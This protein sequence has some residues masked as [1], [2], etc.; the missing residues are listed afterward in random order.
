MEQDKESRGANTYL[1]VPM[2]QR[3]RLT[4]RHALES[5]RKLK[6]NGLE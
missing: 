2:V 4:Q 5:R 6:A 1:N 3:Q